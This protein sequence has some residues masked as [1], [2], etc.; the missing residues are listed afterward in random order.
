[1][2]IGV[3]DP[4]HF[5]GGRMKL[6]QVKAERALEEKV[7]K[8]LG[9]SLLEAADGVLDIIN[10]KMEEAIKAVSSQRGYDIR[11]FILVAFGGGGPMHAGRIA[12]DLGIPTVLIP[13]TPGVHSALG[14]L[15]SDVKHD[16]VRSKLVGLNELDLDETNGLFA[17]LI[18]QAKADLRAEGSTMP[19]SSTPFDLR[20]AGQGYEH[21]SV[22][23]RRK[24]DLD[25]MRQRFDTACKLRAISRKR[26]RW[27]SQSPADFTLV[28][29]R[30][31]LRR[32]HLG[33][34]KEDRR[35][36]SLS[37]AAWYTEL[38]DLRA[39]SGAGHE[40]SARR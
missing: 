27:T 28:P 10:V 25:L 1:V 6:D 20:Y 9:L 12:L 34:M 38:R 8:P 36:E 30:S 24:M 13:L 7:A 39:G 40:I 14:L 11:D 37:K 26:S 23:R 15:M 33:G 2:V 17:R 32:R 19:I 35:E 21:C 29:R 4:N 22:R 18:E 31:F 5:L 3:L 16:Y